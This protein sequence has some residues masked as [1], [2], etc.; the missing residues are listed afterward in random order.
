M[1]G[2]NHGQTR[3]L[4]ELLRRHYIKPGRDLP[5]GVFLPEVGWNGGPQSGRA[6][7]LYIG[8]TSTS[9]RLLVGHEIKVSR[10]DWRAELDKQGKADPW[11]DQCHAWYVVAPSTDV[12]PVE[13]LPHGWGLMLPNPRT[14]TRMQIKVK[15]V[16]HADRRPSWNAVRSIIA[17]QDTLRAQE[18]LSIRTDAR[19]EAR[20]QAE[21][22]YQQR[23]ERRAAALGDH[24]AE[25]VRDIEER[26]GCTFRDF[27]AENHVTPKQ[28]VE[29]LAIA[30]A[31]HALTDQ[32]D[33]LT[34]LV[35]T[36]DTTKTRAEKLI[37]V[38]GTPNGAA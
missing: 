35:R 27:M 13:E 20:K 1:A 12:V 16:V 34:E 14:T 18:I 31:R 11:H 29:A 19:D 17:R 23:A 15:A 25:I 3:T 7:A 22:E 33:G 24:S 30:K 4:L 9:G 8:F 10:S 37:A 21:R 26:L 32:W 6:D 28:F 2:V 5:G 36:L 38:L